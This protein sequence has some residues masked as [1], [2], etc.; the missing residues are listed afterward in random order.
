VLLPKADKNRS[1][2]EPILSQAQHKVQ[3]WHDGSVPVSFVIPCPVLNLIE[4]CF[5]ISVLNFGF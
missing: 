3:A 4:D 1:D 2:A 5:G